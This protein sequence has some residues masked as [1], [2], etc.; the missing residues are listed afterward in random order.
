MCSLLL[1]CFL[2]SLSLSFFPSLLSA[3]AGPYITDPS[4]D[5]WFWGF[6]LTYNFWI[7]GGF[8]GGGNDERE[9]TLNQL[10]VEMDGL[11]EKIECAERDRDYWC[12][13]I[14]PDDPLVAFWPGI[15]LSASGR[16]AGRPPI[17][18]VPTGLDRLILTT[19]LAEV[20]CKIALLILVYCDNTGLPLSCPF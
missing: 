1:F 6:R 5:H 2:L 4:F 8:S 17:K 20:F 19:S 3:L 11:R 12:A 18:M 9:N 10:L 7:K 14:L 13:D 15:A 16:P